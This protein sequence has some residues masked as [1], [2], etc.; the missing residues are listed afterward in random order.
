[1]HNSWSVWEHTLDA[2]LSIDAFYTK[3]QHYLKQETARSTRDSK[4]SFEHVSLQVQGRISH[5]YVQFFSEN[6]YSDLTS[7]LTQIYFNAQKINFKY[8]NWLI[9]K[10]QTAPSVHTIVVCAIS[11]PSKMS[12]TRFSTSGLFWNKLWLLR[13]ITE[14]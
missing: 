7:Y 14:N 8:S 9:L 10:W 3:L 12:V 5:Q 2:I 11:G 4:H 6:T 1:M 13:K